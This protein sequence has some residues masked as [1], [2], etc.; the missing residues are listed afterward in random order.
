M[1]ERK[2][3]HKALRVRAG[4][5][6]TFD[7]HPR[8]AEVGVR[9]ATHAENLMILRARLSEHLSPAEDRELLAAAAAL[10]S[11]IIEEC[12]RVCK[13]YGDSCLK[14]AAQ[15]GIGAD[16][17]DM[18]RDMNLAA[19][20]IAERIRAL[21]PREQNAAPPNGPSEMGR[22]IDE[23]RT[24]AAPVAW[25][26]TNEEGD[27]DFG[28]NW[29]ALADKSYRGGPAIPLYRAAPSLSREEWGMMLA[30]IDHQYSLL[31][32]YD[33]ELKIALRAKVRE[34]AKSRP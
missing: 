9:S 11:A 28:N 21:A 27:D 17:Q 15:P 19:T 12:A 20:R 23:K 32:T 2:E 16:I 7:P 29:T 3:G 34:A 30:Y 22:M 13:E 31:D 14:N 5:L 25:M 6:E 18:W 4:E 8:A 33:P 1:S 10:S 24:V 26:F